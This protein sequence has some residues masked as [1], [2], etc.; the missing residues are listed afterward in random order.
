M[1]IW[2]VRSVLGLAAL[3][4]LAGLVI[5]G[6]SEAVVAWRHPTALPQ[7]QAATDA[8]AVPRGA[9]LAQLYGC[10]GCHE[11]NL[12]GALFFDEP[13]VAVVWTSN[14]TQAM[15]HYT[16]AQLARAIRGGVRPDGSSLMGMP[17]ESWIAVT[18]P[19]MADLLAW[20]RSHPPAGPVHPRVK[21]G[22]MGRIGVLAGQFKPS[23][24]Y[25]TEAA[26]M[27]A[28]DLGPAY[29]AARHTAL[30]VCSECHGADLK[31]RP[32]DTPDLM[33]AASYDLPG[34]TRLMRTGIA[35]D[36]KERGLMTEVSRGRFSHFSDAEIADL[37]AYLV[38]RAEAAP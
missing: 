31:G 9:R 19:E 4:L 14:L 17:S 34:F 5:G 27:T 11:P 29:A 12:Q 7:V 20:L 28:A 38:A 3:M 18:D 21:L 16:D 1:Q 35:A 6:G 8:G 37:H 13:L 30:T 2:I 32:G 36:G 23:P 33:I 22:L 24:A 10:N 25:V 15:P 26:A